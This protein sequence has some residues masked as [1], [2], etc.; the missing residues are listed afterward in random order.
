MKGI[1]PRLSTAL[2]VYLSLKGAGRPKTFE[3]GARRA[4]GYLLAVADDKPLDAYV[5]SDANALREHLR[6]PGCVALRPSLI[7]IEL[8]N[9][10]IR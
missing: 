6:G 4:V 2:E 9:P 1:G 8:S 7:W 10:Q 3:A 5:R